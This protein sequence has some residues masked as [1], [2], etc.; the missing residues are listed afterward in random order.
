MADRGYVHY[1]ELVHTDTMEEHETYVVWLKHTAMSSFTFAP[2]P[3]PMAM[4]DVT[5][6]IDYNFMPN[7]MMPYGTMHH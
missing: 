3:M 1:H 5:P 6:G 2:M 7:Y 4:H